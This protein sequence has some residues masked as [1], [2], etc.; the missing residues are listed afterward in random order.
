MIDFNIDLVKEHA[1]IDEIIK[2]W[3]IP[4]NMI[5]AWGDKKLS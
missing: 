3:L 5:K 1:L 2:A 4:E